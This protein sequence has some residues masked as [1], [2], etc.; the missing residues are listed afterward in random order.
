[1]YGYVRVE[2]HDVKLNE[3]KFTSNEGSI[4]M[5]REK[6]TQEAGKKNTSLLLF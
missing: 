3:I 2:Y 5:F 6:Q 1:M 4:C